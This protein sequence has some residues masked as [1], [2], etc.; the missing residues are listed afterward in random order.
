VIEHQFPVN[1][2]QRGLSLD[3]E[4]L[5]RSVN[6]ALP[7]AAQRQASDPLFPGGTL[8]PDAPNAENLLPGQ[9]DAD[10]PDGPDDEL[11]TGYLW[12]NALRARLTVRDY[13][14]FVDT[15]C[16]NV[17]ACQTPLAHD[18]FATNTIVAPSA[19]VALA[20]YTDP[21][22]RGFDPSFPDYYRFK[23]WERDFDTNYAQGGMANLTLVRFMHDHTGNFG[24]AIDLVNTP[25]RDQADNDYARGIARAENC[26]QSRVQK[27]HSDFCRGRR[28]A[29]WRR[30]HRFSPHHRIRR[31]RLREGCSRFYRIHHGR[32]RAHDRRGFGIAAHESERRSGDA[33]GRHLQYGA[34]PGVDFHGHA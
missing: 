26:Q 12:N 27:Q 30:S 6:V 9:A 11:N 4:G 24:T 23:E 20:P 18:P 21:Y 1:Y 17:P 5:N 3:S 19:N 29:G 2:S 25:D 33:H 31:G 16:Y 32:L 13:G 8:S 28:L 14:W 22:F 7:T 15:T 34:E 10:A